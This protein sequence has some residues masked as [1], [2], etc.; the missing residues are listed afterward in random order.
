MFTAGVGVSSLPAARPAAEQAAEAA[1]AA[2]ARAEFGVLFCTPDHAKHLPELLEVAAG[3]LGTRTVIGATAHGVLGEGREF[4]DGPALCVLALAGVEAEPFLLEDVPGHEEAV[5]EEIAQRLPGSP[6]EQD[7]VLLLPDPRVIRPQRLLPALGEMLGPARVVG[8][9]A[10]DPISNRP[11]QFSRGRIRTEA[12]AG[13]A[14]RLPRPP[15]IGVTQ[16]CRPVT[17]RLGVTR[18]RG[19]W[20]L[21]LDGR[22]ALDVYRDAARGPLAEDLQRAA[23]FV[24]VALP[25]DSQAPLRPGGYRVRNVV[26]FALEEGAFALPE[27]VAPGQGLALVHREPEAARDD[28]KEMLGALPGSPA[29]A[30]LYLNCCARGSSLFGVAGLEAGYLESAFGA[31]PIA[32]MLGSCEIGPIAGRTELLTYTGV[33]ALFDA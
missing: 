1:L 8:A 21:E 9:G 17:E 4:E 10:A 22:R 25:L 32:G 2:S 16:A 33:L 19:N 30:G 28:L 7:L 29:R 20:V 27:P 15:R 3:T 14:L 12:M 6:R 24:L 26:G 18:A 23:A 11:L 5:A 31:M 13:L